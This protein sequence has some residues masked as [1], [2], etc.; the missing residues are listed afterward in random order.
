MLPASSNRKH[1]R[2][3]GKHCAYDANPCSTAPPREFRCWALSPVKSGGRFVADIFGHPDEY[4]ISRDGGFATRGDVKS[5]LHCPR[6]RRRSVTICSPR[7][8]A[9]FSVVL[10]SL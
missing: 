10:V 5:G 7:A 9:G 6:R 3:G 4:Q 1:G 2:Q 8:D